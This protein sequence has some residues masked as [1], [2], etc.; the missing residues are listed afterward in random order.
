VSICDW[1]CDSADLCGITT[2]EYYDTSPEATQRFIKA[3][4]REHTL[5]GLFEKLGKPN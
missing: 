4:N 5:E 2:C 1:I 3:L